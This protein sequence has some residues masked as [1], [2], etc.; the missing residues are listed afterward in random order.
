VKQRTK[1]GYALGTEEQY[2]HRDGLMVQAI[3]NIIVNTEIESSDRKPEDS[4]ST[5]SEDRGIARDTAFQETQLTK[6]L[7]FGV[8][9]VE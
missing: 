3:G 1:T 5:C 4:V 9:A 6:N 2:W 8:P 7:R